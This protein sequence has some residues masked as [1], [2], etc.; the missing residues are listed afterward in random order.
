MQKAIYSENYRR[1]VEWLKSARE[2]RGWS[3]RDLGELID[4]PHSFVQKVESMERRLDVFE[5]VQ[6]CSVLG[7][8]PA[9]GLA[10]LK[11]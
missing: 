11:R 2:A 7:L 5:Y 1:L 3:M 8:N 9:D 6:Y 10:V 4:E